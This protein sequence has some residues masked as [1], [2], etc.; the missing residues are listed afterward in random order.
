MKDAVL[1]RFTERRQSNL[2]SLYKYL[3]NPDCLHE[4][5]EHE[6]FNMPS[7]TVLQKTAKFSPQKTL[8]ILDQVE[9][10]KGQKEAEEQL[11]LQEEMEEAIEHSAKKQR[12]NSKYEFKAISKEMMVFE[13]TSKKTANLELLFNA[14]E[15]IPPTSVESERALSAAGLFVTKIRSRM[16]DDLLDTLRFLKAHF[17][18]KNKS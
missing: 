2:V 3:S 8:K 17:L 11:S 4:I 12:Y 6:I 10:G 18:L 13:A 9:R 14:L 5:E 16:S 15:T 7:K 1:K